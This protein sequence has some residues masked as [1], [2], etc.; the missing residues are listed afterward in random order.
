MSFPKRTGGPW[1]PEKHITQIHPSSSY[2]D[3][4]FRSFPSKEEDEGFPPLPISGHTDSHLRL[5]YTVSLPGQG[6]VADTEPDIKRTSRINDSALS[7]SPLFS[8]Y[9]FC[10]ILLPTA[11][12]SK[13]RSCIL[14]ASCGNKALHWN[15]WHVS[16]P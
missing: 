16:L 5:F 4:P 6:T 2:L 9:F 12:S 13:F 1:V 8:L 15:S 7:P 3:A 10:P 14:D 11:M